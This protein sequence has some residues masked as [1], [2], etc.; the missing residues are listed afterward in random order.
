MTVLFSLRKPSVHAKSLVR[1][2]R[3]GGK[4]AIRVHLNATGPRLPFSAAMGCSNLLRSIRTNRAVIISGKNVLVHVTRIHPSELVYSILARNMF[5]SHHR[6]GLPNMTLQLPTL[7]RGSLTSLTITMRYR[8]SCMTVSFIQ[9]TTRVT[10]LQR[11][12]SGLKNGTRVITGVRSRRTIHRVSSVVLTTSIV[13]ITHKSLNVRID[14][15][16]LPV[17]RHHVIHRYRE[18]KHHY[19]ITARV[20]RSVVAR[21]GPAHTRI[22]SISGTV[23]RR[24]S[25]IV[26]SK[27]ASINR[28]PMH[29]IRILSSVTR[30]VRYSNGLGFTTSTVL[31][32]SHRGTAGTTVSLTSSIRGTYLVI[33]AHH[34]L[35]T[36]R[37]TILEP[38]QTTVFTF[39]GSPIIIERLTLTHSMATFRSPFLGSPTHVVSATLSL[40]G[41]GKL[42]SSNRPIIVRKS[43]LRKR[44]LT[45][46]VVF[47]HI[48][49]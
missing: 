4:S 24:I 33:F 38:R 35:T 3:L 44:L 42:V 21:P 26:L 9:S 41:R 36:A 5:N 19:V 8:A 48:R 10:R 31:G 32:K 43:D 18:L 12:V 30:H 28:C 29:Y 2:C 16:R 47:V 7:A 20:L 14:V 27:R 13:V 15:R 1:P 25:T 23:F 37:T 6:V 22:A 34:N 17:V 40:L 49:W 11:R 45:S 46:S 39:D